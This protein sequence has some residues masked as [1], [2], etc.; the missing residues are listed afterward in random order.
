MHIP[1]YRCTPESSIVRA[2]MFRKQDATI[3]VDAVV[4]DDYVVLLLADRLHEDVYGVALDTGVLAMD[5]S[6]DPTAMIQQPPDL[7]CVG[8]GSKKNECGD[9]GQKS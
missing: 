9:K 1:W 7:S 8:A 4:D 2:Q 5:P 3:V 6:P